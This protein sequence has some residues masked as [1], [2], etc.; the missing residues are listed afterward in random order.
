[1]GT[2]VP[3]D[4]PDLDPTKWYAY[5]VDVFQD[6]TPATG[7]DQE[8]IMTINCC[9]MG[10][11]LEDWYDV[12]GPCVDGSELCPFSGFSSQR[13]TCIMGPYDSYEECCEANP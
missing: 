2:P 12:G 4:F 8:F 11:A 3:D 6:E 7:C 5:Y 10:G 13:P 9:A 1:M